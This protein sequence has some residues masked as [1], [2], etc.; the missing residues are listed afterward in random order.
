MSDFF[1]QTFSAFSTTGTPTPVVANDPGPGSGSA[2]FVQGGAFGGL[3][4]QPLDWGSPTGSQGANPL[5]VI[6]GGLNTITSQGSA[7]GSSA[8]PMLPTLAPT[9][10]I[11]TPSNAQ[12]TAQPQSSGGIS[13]GSLADYFVRAVIVILGFIF[14]AIGLNMFK[15]G[16]V[17]VPVPGLRR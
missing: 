6:G 12:T 8:T 14:V 3:N 7:S 11:G 17:P 4:F 13:S 5:P 9:N 15:P 2:Q 10:A 1:D 16:I